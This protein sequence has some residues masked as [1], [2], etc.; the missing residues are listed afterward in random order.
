MTGFRLHTALKEQ[1]LRKL[2]ALYELWIGSA[3][4]NRDEDVINHLVTQLQHPFTV[5]QI[6]SEVVGNT[7]IILFDLINSEKGINIDYWKDS[8]GFESSMK[9]LDYLFELGLAY[10]KEDKWFVPVELKKSLKELPRT[11]VANSSLLGLHGWLN[12][13]LAPRMPRELLPNVLSNTYAVLQSEESIRERISALPEDAKC[14]LMT[15]INEYGGLVG[16]NKI[17]NNFPGIDIN[18]LRGNPKKAY[19]KLKFKPKYNF[20][21]L[22]KTMLDHDLNDA[23]KEKILIENQ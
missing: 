4:P 5:S 9:S 3:P 23:K 11:D 22:I 12:H 14:F 2:Y 13:H 7:Q 20:T 6:A 15:L 8:F 16:V 10:K 1:S 21:K 18:Y 19:K 17:Q